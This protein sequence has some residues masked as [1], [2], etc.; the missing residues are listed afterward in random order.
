MSRKIEAASSGAVRMS[1]LRAQA[2]EVVGRQACED[3][4][5]EDRVDQRAVG[6]LDEDRHDAEHD[7]ADQG[8]EECA[9]E[10]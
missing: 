3:H 2:L 10:P 9:G 8:P 5:S 6:D 1:W 7:Q 4:Q